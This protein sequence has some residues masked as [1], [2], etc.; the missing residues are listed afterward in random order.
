MHVTIYLIGDTYSSGSTYRI[1]NNTG[2]SMH[3]E[4]KS[5]A[6]KKIPGRGTNKGG[7]R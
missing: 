4:R 2:W 3:K 1:F 5:L 6:S 7:K